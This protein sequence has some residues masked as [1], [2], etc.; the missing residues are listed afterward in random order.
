[1]EIRASFREAFAELNQWILSERRKW[2]SRTERGEELDTLLD[3]H[4]DFFSEWHDRFAGQIAKTAADFTTE[5]RLRHQSFIWQSDY[6]RLLQEA[7]YYW[8]IIN[9][10]EGYSGDAEMMSI[11]YRKTY[12][13]DTPFGRLVH[14]SAA[15]CPACQAVRNRRAFLKEKIEQKKG[16]ILS[17]AA[18]PAMEIRDVLMQ[19][20][21]ED[22]YQCH[23]Y[24]HDIKTV[25]KTCRECSDPRLTYMVGN[26]F[27]LIKGS[28]R[29]ALPRQMTLA[30]CNPRSDFK[31]VRRFLVPLKYS[32][33][34]LEENA[35][36][37]VY[38]AGLYDYIK[39]F[40]DEP[41]KGTVA[42]TR[43]LFQLVKPGG[44]LIIGNFSP[45]NP[46]SIRFVMEYVCDWNLFHR[47]REEMI[48]FA[49]S[50]PEQEIDTM[51]IEQEPLGI[52][53][54]LVIRKK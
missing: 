46:Q 40:P 20:N 37:L 51:T 47:T 27:H 9:K 45:N 43:N 50:I 36:D 12:E 30:H 35:Y 3:G 16:K 15:L 24:D 49:R 42:L 38:S 14:K 29:V 32:L 28:Y 33:V 18:G 6:H 21:S 54:F 4:I 41:E 19:D 17:V 1:M 52:N 10:P 25:R 31:G 5:D 26:A 34:N 7:P 44:S 8:Q 2:N 39:T 22:T 23:A 53:Y 48:D 11:I 13:G